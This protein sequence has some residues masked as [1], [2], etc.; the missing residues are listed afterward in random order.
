M[1]QKVFDGAVVMVQGFE[2]VVSDV[3]WFVP[4]PMKNDPC[5]GEEIVRFVGKC[6]ANKGNDSIRGTAY[7]GGTYGGNRLA[8]YAKP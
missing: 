2:M 6:T 4:E 1:A 5:P 7:D 8:G 3:R